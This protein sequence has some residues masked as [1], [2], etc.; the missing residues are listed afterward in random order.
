MLATT[1]PRSAAG[2]R[3]LS[4]RPAAF[5]AAALALLVILGGA[6]RAGAA[7]TPAALWGWPQ[8]G[9]DA[10][11]R[12]V[13]D[14][15]TTLYRGNVGTLHLL[16]QVTL[17][18]IAD[19]AP[20]LLPGAATAHGT[21]DLLF[22]TTKDG[23]L[24]ALDAATGKTVWSAQP[25]TGPL[26]TTS[27]PAIDPDR[28]HVYSY[29]LDGRVHKYAVA[30]GSEVTGGGWPEVATL[31][32]DVEK[33]SSALGIA[34]TA[35]NGG[36]TYLYVA[37]SGYPDDAGDYQGHVTVIDLA[38]GAQ[39]VWNAMC[40]ARHVH[41]VEGG[42]PDCRNL[43]GAVWGRPGVVYDP[44]VERIFFATGNGLFDG[45]RSWGD[46]ILAL[47]PDGTGAGMGPVDSYTPANFQELQDDD[48]DL[49]S[50]TPV[51]LP[52]P[53]GSRVP[54]LGAHVGKDSVIRLLDLDDL[55]GTGRPG[56]VGGELQALPLPQTDQVLPQPAVWVDPTD[57]STW[58]FVAN[59][60]GISGLRLALDGAGNPGLV[61]VWTNRVAGTSPVLANGILVYAAVGV[62][63]QAL[64]PTTGQ[65]LWTDTAAVNPH[66]HWESPIVAGGRIFITDESKALR[67]Y[68][69]A[70]PPLVF[71]AL[72]T[73]RA[74]DTRGGPSPFA[75]PSLSAAAGQRL[76]QVAGRCGVPAGARAVAATVIAT[77]A[78]APG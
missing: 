59:F 53:P 19:G 77:R 39:R 34:T 31:K 11:H 62:G 1:R 50:S 42:V 58:L 30:D 20:A 10:R 44:D 36:A 61:P 8:F 24:L 52:A 41:F 35:T 12:G 76:V 45:A 60:D 28:A 14:R 27:S 33:G 43:Q 22:L 16:Y 4:R 68:A 29:G 25:A 5:A 13:N 54:H 65:V 17:P 75:G 70:A 72:L 63:L 78:S 71:H 47:R 49:G 51:L 26:F 7:G 21:R 40:S 15:E 56:A 23:R 18:A 48:L 32:P 69:P 9:F 57:G 66:W 46:T 74:L 67:A 37:N 64:D 2:S 73:C 3:F 6:G 38:T 55:S